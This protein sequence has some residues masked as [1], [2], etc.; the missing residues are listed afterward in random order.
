MERRSVLQ[1][2]FEID[3]D[4]HAVVSCDGGAPS[5]LLD[6]MLLQKLPRILFAL[7]LEEKLALTDAILYFDLQARHGPER[8]GLTLLLS[9][10]WTWTSSPPLSFFVADKKSKTVTITSRNAHVVVNGTNVP[11]SVTVLMLPAMEVGSLL[12]KPSRTIIT[13]TFPS[14]DRHERNHFTLD[15]GEE[16]EDTRLV[17]SRWKLKDKTPQCLLDVFGPEIE[18]S[19]DL[20]RLAVSGFHSRFYSMSP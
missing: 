5:S 2:R 1:G 8:V 18:K 17:V 4:R 20:R 3:S 14:I 16:R 10:P 15:S 11:A 7:Q 9:S 13:I 12:S 19:F 6:E